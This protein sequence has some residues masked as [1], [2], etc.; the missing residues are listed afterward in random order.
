MTPAEP[1]VSITLAWTALPVVLPLLFT[2]VVLH[3]GGLKGRVDSLEREIEKKRATLAGVAV[4]DAERNALAERTAQLAE[5]EAMVTSDSERIAELSRIAWKNGVALR[6]LRSEQAALTDGGVASCAH[7]VSA[8]GTYRQLAAFLDDIYAAR[9]LAGIDQLEIRPDGPPGSN[10]LLA[11]LG[12]RWFAKGPAVAE[13]E[14]T[15]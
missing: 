7:A 1:R 13:P 2:G 15:Q 4:P 10:L 3:L 6:S 5:W 14:V 8:L 9:G 12:V 11:T